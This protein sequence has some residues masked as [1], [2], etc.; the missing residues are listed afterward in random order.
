[1][2]LNDQEPEAVQTESGSRNG[3][4]LLHPASSWNVERSVHRVSDAVDR[5]LL[6][7]LQS[8]E[9]V[10]M[11]LRDYLPKP[12]QSWEA[13]IDTK[14]EDSEKA[15]WGLNQHHANIDDELEALKACGRLVIQFI[16]EIQNVSKVI[17]G[18]TRGWKEEAPDTRRKQHPDVY[19]KVKVFYATDRK[20]TEDAEYVGERSVLRGLHYGL[21]VVGIP[22]VHKAGYVEA[23]TDN[24]EEAN[25]LKHVVI[26]SIDT[27]LRG[28]T[29][30]FIRTINK[31]LDQEGSSFKHNIFLY[32]HG[33]NVHH[34]DAIK[35]AAQLKYDLQLE[36]VVIVYSWPSKGTLWGY[37][38]DEKVVDHTA[39]YLESFIQTILSEVCSDAK[40]HI[41]AH[42]MGNRALIKALQGFQ[43]RHHSLPQPMR[44]LTNII[45]AAAD[46]TRTKFENMVTSLGIRTE[47]AEVPPLITVY[48][49][50]CD[51]ALHT[52]KMIHWKVRLGDTRSLFERSH[53][54]DHS[55]MMNPPDV[56]DASGVDAS[57]LHHS[58]YGDVPEV[59]RD[60]QDLLTSSSAKERARQ[61]DPVIKPV[62]YNDKHFYAFKPSRLQK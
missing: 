53:C 49:S 16:S 20:I 10:A 40:V 5:C 32:I 39:S 23:P 30:G 4:E 47:G 31:E 43:F 61:E 25:P 42:S 19:T 22:N 41:L 58:Y 12:K 14:L 3:Q 62:S 38:H 9:E 28:D 34:K 36:G 1:M 45:F 15:F 26:L 21:V 11:L 8:Q 48:S 56:V 37:Q 7:Y 24:S 46:E 55:M 44:S 52:S 51:I 35:R 27:T 60:I 29:T 59:I 2:S 33:Y 18:A 57:R 54:G 17:E 50:I 6:P 13:F